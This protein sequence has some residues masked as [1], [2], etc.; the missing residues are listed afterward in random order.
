MAN[1][2]LEENIVTLIGSDTYKYNLLKGALKAHVGEVVL[3]ERVKNNGKFVGGIVGFT[4]GKM[5]AETYLGVIKSP[6]I[7]EFSEDT[8]SLIS[9]ETILKGLEIM[10]EPMVEF[11]SHSKTIDDS[12]IESHMKFYD[13]NIAFRLED[14]S[15]EEYKNFDGFGKSTQQTAEFRV[16]AG[17][18]AVGRFFEKNYGQKHT[19]L[20]P[21]V[22]N[23]LKDPLKVSK[24]KYYNNALE[25]EKIIEKIEELLSSEKM[26]KTKITTITESAK[27]GE[28]TIDEDD[29]VVV[30]F[31]ER[32]QVKEVRSSIL[33]YIKK[34]ESINMHITPRIYIKETSP[35]K[36]VTINVPEYINGLKETYKK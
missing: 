12:N 28:L 31:N 2:D 11:N 29:A 30:T 7:T 16:Y 15:G 24:I 9:I 23:L 21:A 14:F 6:A 8:R 26:L 10:V 5:P 22:T 32:L 17:D 1:Y 27:K 13:T 20:T 36:K 19:K 18:E 25:E 35:G 3:V 33:S 4:G 34:A